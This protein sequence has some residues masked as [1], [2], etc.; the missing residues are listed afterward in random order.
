MS[1]LVPYF[2]QL[3]SFVNQALLC[4]GEAE[5]IRTI[6]EVEEIYATSAHFYNLSKFYSTTSVASKCSFVLEI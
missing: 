4:L 6:V 1:M 3:F 5:P 2:Q